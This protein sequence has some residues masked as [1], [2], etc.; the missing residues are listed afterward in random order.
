MS[1]S[2]WD[3]NLP[4]E[5]DVHIQGQMRHQTSYHEHDVHVVHAKS[6]RDAYNQAK[7]GLNPNLNITKVIVVFLGIAIL[8][9]IFLR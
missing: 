1:K 7:G 8:A 5:Y 9:S 6:P 4:G 3:R 2:K